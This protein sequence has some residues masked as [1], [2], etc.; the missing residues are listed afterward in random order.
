VLRSKSVDVGLEKVAAT[1]VGQAEEGV[2]KLVDHRGES[3]LEDLTGETVVANEHWRTHV[4]DM[5]AVVSFVAVHAA[6]FKGLVALFPS[7]A[8]QF[9]RRVWPL[10][11]ALF[12]LGN[13]FESS[14]ALETTRFVLFAFGWEKDNEKVIFAGFL[15]VLASAREGTIGLVVVTGPDA[16]KV[17][18][19]V[20]AVDGTLLRFPGE[21]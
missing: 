10:A 16:E 21:H 4:D 19:A 17:V 6:S 11:P 14:R 15:A 5:V 18:L 7:L 20:L 13:L 8:L 1:I 3:H 2:A 9:K 12:A